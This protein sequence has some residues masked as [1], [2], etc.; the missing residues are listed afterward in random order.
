[1]SK[2]PFVS[3]IIITYNGIKFIPDCI[4]SLLNQDYP[5]NKYEIIIG[6]NKSQDDSL[7]LFN[8]DYKDDVKI[9][10]FRKNYGFASGNNKALK[11][12]NGELVVFLNQ[13]VIV[14]KHWLSGLVNG[15]V[16]YRLEACCSNIIMPRNREFK[17]KGS[18]DLP[19]KI[20]YYEINKYGYVDQKIKPW[21][22]VYVP[23]N[24]LSGASFIIKKDIIKNLGYIFD[25]RLQAYNED[26]D[27]S[28]Y[29][30]KNGYNIGMI[31]DSV[32]YHISSFNFKLS[33]FNIWKNII[34]IRNRYIVYR[35]YMNLRKYIKYLPYLFISQSHKVYMRCRQMR[36]NNLKTILLSSSVIPFSLYA[37]IKLFVYKIK[38]GSIYKG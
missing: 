32:V 37:M 17:Y 24:F 31:P 30:S 25:E 20:H 11:Y 38:Y 6:D 16:H 19:S 7:K 27:L 34:I 29:L 35:K 10:E 28:L 8:R 22:S 33:K 4:S 2:T 1:M 23:V 15:I 21:K 36:Y 12:A 5:R 14:H 26:L 3:I 9:I 18:S 13:D